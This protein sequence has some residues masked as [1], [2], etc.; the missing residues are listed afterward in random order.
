MWL[1]VKLSQRPLFLYFT[2]TMIS[3]LR[4]FYCFTCIHGCDTTS[5]LQY[6]INYTNLFFLRTHTINKTTNYSIWEGRGLLLLPSGLSHV[7][8]LIKIKLCYI[9]YCFTGINGITPQVF[10][11]KSKIIIK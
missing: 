4:T 10:C 8:G 5:I 2:C 9:F 1:D 11:K 7:Y 6:H 3:E